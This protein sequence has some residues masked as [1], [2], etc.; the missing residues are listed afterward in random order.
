MISS[1]P[2]VL[3]QQEAVGNLTLEVISVSGVIKEKVFP[4]KLEKLENFQ[5]SSI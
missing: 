2:P 4:L 1:M 3:P 5:K